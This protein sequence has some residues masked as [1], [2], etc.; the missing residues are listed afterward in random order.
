M[1]F[2]YKLNYVMNYTLSINYK[3]YVNELIDMIFNHT[4]KNY[5]FG[6]RARQIG[7][8]LYNQGGVD[9]LFICM[10]MIVD[11]MTNEYSNEYLGSLRELEFCWT[12]LGD[13]QA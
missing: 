13:F 10:N 11:K 5:I 2:F 8:N 9:S 3:I 7:Q 4:S 12:G 6:K 1:N